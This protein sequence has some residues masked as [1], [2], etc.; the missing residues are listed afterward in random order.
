MIRGAVSAT[1]E[2]KI[3]LSFLDPAVNPLLLDV[4]IDTAFAGFLVLPTIIITQ[5]SLPSLGHFDVELADG[6]FAFCGYFEVRVEWMGA[7][8]V[9]LVI[10]MGTSP[11]VGV[12]FFW[13]HRLTIDVIVGGDVN[14]EPLP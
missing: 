8:R 7:V 12:N 2:P 5:L 10:E 13:G 6:T 1:L 14:I 11:L 9:V 4:E 3:A